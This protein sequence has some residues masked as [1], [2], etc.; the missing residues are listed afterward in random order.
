M[1]I[2]WVQKKEGNVYPS[3]RSRFTLIELLVVIAIIAILAS[4]LLPAL[5]KAREKAKNIFCT[6][7]LKSLGTAH[8]FY[9]DDF[10]YCLMETQIKHAEYPGSSDNRTY[11]NDILLSYLSK[12]YKSFVCPSDPFGTKV[13]AWKGSVG[14][15]IIDPSRV[16][17]GYNYEGI[18]VNRRGSNNQDER[19]R[20]KPSKIKSPAKL[21]TFMDSAYCAD[22]THGYYS[23]RAAMPSNPSWIGMPNF[24]RHTWRMNIVFM[25]NHI[26]S[27][28]SKSI[29]NPWAEDALGSR[30]SCSKGLA[31]WTYD[32][33]P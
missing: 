2:Q 30:A 29:S 7:N 27:F 10:D 23:A 16:S 11:W 13:V 1:Q 20:V 18:S 21:F 33:K 12:N 5:S 19:E 8:Q 24:L 31:N 17:Y 9:I 26:E 25:D 14:Q 6:N 32:G 22:P 3:D 15:Y 4:M 28:A